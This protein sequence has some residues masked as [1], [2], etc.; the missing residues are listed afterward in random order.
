MKKF[1]KHLKE[2]ATKVINSEKK[3]TI[4]LTYKEN[5]SY[6]NQ[7]VCYIWKKYLLLMM[8]IKNII[9]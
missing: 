9:K 3:E 7:E 2:H 8:A 5:E 6:K 1:C 4:P